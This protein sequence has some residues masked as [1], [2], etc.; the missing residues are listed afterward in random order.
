M[1][2]GRPITRAHRNKL[3]LLIKI[4]KADIAG[5]QDPLLGLIHLNKEKEDRE[6]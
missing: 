5:E 1:N 2:M 3:F 6:K 4:M